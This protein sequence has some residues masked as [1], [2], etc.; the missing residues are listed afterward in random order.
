MAFERHQYAGAAAKTTLASDISAGAITLTLTTSTGWPDGTVGPFLIVIDRGQP[1]EEKILVTTRTGSALNFTVPNRGAEGT[2]AASH[3]AGVFVEHI[4]GS[5]D[6]DEANLAVVNTIGKVTTKGDLIV[7]SAANTFARVAGPG[8]SGLVLTSDPSQPAGVAWVSPGA[9]LAA[10]AVNP[11]V[12]QQ[13]PMPSGV[14]PPPAAPSILDHNNVRAPFI[15]P[16]SGRFIVEFD[17]VMNAHGAGVDM[18]G[19]L[20]FA[21][22]DSTTPGPFT[23]AHYRLFTN[24]SVT[25]GDER[26]IHY[27][28]LV[29]SADL[30]LLTPGSL[31]TV[32]PAATAIGATAAYVAWGGQ[33]AGTPRGAFT[34]KVL[35]A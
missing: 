5:R 13:V 29:V 21:A 14:N 24:G 6:A 15:V 4:I 26:M 3:K 9:V 17:C 31:V 7:A 25:G 22:G 18:Y 1:A 32:F 33:A 12:V 30:P 19:A 10:V 11:S 23:I 16:P 27:S 35:A 2:S 8:T 34:I 20:M 28:Q